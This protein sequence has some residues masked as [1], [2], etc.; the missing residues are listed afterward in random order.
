MSSGK[1]LTTVDRTVQIIDALREL[2][3]ARVNEVADHL[4]MAPSTVHAHLSTLESNELLVRDGDIYDLGMRFLQLGKYAQRRREAYVL[5]DEY[6]KQVVEETGYRTI[7]FVV[8]HGKGVFVHMYSGEHPPWMH[9]DAGQRAR[10]HS[11]AA[12]K[13][14]LAYEPEAR[15][16][17]ILETHGMPA[18][19]ENTITSPDEYLLELEAVRRAGVA[20]NDCENVEGIR[21]VAVPAMSPAGEVIGSFSVSGPQN[22]MPDETFESE[23]PTILKGIVDEYE[24]ELTL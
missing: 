14:I 4:E 8:E 17:E 15:V 18:K 7:F 16:R 24:L 1:T 20:F 21:A 12:A 10:V 23:L 6:T 5:A 13:A 2:D 11:L 9:T 19:T 22:R 3:G